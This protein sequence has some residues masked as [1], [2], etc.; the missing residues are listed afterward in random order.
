M[1]TPRPTTGHR[2]LRPVDPHN[3]V[4]PPGWTPESDRREEFADISV[5]AVLRRAK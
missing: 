5:L 2:V 4:P 1:P 3:N